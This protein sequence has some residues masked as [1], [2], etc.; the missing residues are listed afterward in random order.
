VAA[1]TQHQTRGGWR[2]GAGRP[3]LPEELKRTEQSKVMWTVDELA[4]L[5]RAVAYLNANGRADLIRQ[6][7]LEFIEGLKAHKA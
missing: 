6:A 2:P 5:D 1:K 4:R 7:V 3:K